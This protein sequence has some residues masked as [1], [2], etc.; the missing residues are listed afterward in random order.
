MG[1]TVAA[2]RRKRQDDHGERRM[3]HGELITSTSVTPWRRVCPSIEPGRIQSLRQ[4]F[5]TVA[6][7]APKETA[8]RGSRPAV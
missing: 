2:E 1:G 5:Q 7:N 4:V 6:K 3:R 8:G